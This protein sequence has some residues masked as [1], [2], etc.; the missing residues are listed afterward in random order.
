MWK[1][2]TLSTTAKIGPLMMCRV[3]STNFSP[4]SMRQLLSRHGLAVRQM[5]PLALDA[6]YV[7]MLSEKHRSPERAGGPLT[8]LR[9]GYSSNRYAAQHD[10]QYSSVL[11]V[12][13]RVA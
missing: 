10:G 5:L 3:T 2:S 11:Y 4:A 13:E 7:S 8:V 9:A 1:A 6:Y 12:A